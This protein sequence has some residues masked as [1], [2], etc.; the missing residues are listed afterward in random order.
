MTES[1]VANHATNGG[2]S[3]GADVLA[4]VRALAPEIEARAAETE[5]RRRLPAD[6]IKQLQEA[7]CFRLQVPARLG[8]EEADLTTFLRVCEEVAR[9]D[10]AAGWIVMILGS[11]PLATSHLPLETFD[12]IYA[13]G[14]DVLTGGSIVPKPMAVATDGGY[15]VT[16]E[17]PLASGSED[18][19]WVIAHALIFENGQ[20]RMV[21][22]MP[23][24]RLMVLPASDVN[25]LDTW[26]VSG[27]KGTGSQDFRL[28][29][30]QV[31][32]ERACNLFG[33][34]TIDLPLFRIPMFVMAAFQLSAIGLG[35]AQAAVDE[36]ASLATLKRSHLDPTTRLAEDPIAQF[37]IGKVQTGVRAA[38][39]L[40]YEEAERVW[41]LSVD[42][43]E[44]SPLERVEV[45]SAGWYATT[46]AV[47]AVDTAYSLGGST[48]L[49]ESSPLQ[50]YVRDIRGLTQHYGLS[51]NN[52]KSLG[53]VLMGEAPPITALL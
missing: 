10:A 22:G 47:E 29:G 14:P 4:R 44:M 36:L 19:E 46:L 35:I 25:I 9:A 48:A 24:A 23:D 37:Q 30:V 6:L 11:T 8:G 15:R 40:M 2:T 52:A 5:A 31:P 13:S 1:A 33:P 3:G 45:R 27:L 32:E 53:M 18:C 51:R 42:G 28:E 17:W 7:G 49:Y 26:Y 38:R 39:A 16:G 50:R 43:H 12:A 20:P 41:Q 34:A 21:G